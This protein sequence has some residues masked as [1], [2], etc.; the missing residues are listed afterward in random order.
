M[1]P[2]CGKWVILT[3]H[4]V[5]EIGKKLLVCRGCHDV[6]ERYAKALEKMKH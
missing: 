1:C 5:K 3:E 6:I 4:H 2:C